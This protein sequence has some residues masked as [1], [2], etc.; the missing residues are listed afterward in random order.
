MQHSEKCH[1]LNTPVLTRCLCLS[2]SCHSNRWVFKAGFFQPIV[3]DMY[4]REAQL[5]QNLKITAVLIMSV[6]KINSTGFVH[7]GIF[8]KQKEKGV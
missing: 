1:V 8:N 4:N 5:V 2:R 3:V 7:L 6:F